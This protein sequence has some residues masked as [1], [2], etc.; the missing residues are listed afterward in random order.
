MKKKILI[1]ILAVLCAV[2]LICGA[3][4]AWRHVKYSGYTR[5]MES[6]GIKTAL[7]PRY[8]CKDAEGFDFSVKYPDV[9]SL[10]GN[11]AVGMPGTPENPFT[12]GLIIWPKFTGGYEYGVILIGDESEEDWQIYIDSAGNAID[13]E[14]QPVIDDHRK[15]VDILLEK[16]FGFWE[17]K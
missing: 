15:T 2:V 1:T 17:L 16:A 13:S 4:F 12:D 10:T 6:S 3:W 5:N 14:Y 7:V 8:V 11:L 9:L